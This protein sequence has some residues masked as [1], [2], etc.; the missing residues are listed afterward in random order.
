MSNLTRVSPVSQLLLFNKKCRRKTGAIL[1]SRV[2]TGALK[3]RPKISTRE[4]RDNKDSCSPRDNKRTGVTEEFTPINGVM[5]K[6]LEEKV[7]R[8]L[9]TN[10]FMREQ[11]RLNGK[12]MELNQ[13]S[14]TGKKH[15]LLL[16][17]K[18]GAIPELREPTGALKRRP[19]I[20]T[21]GQRDNRDSCS[22]R[23]N[24]KTGAIEEFTPMS[25]AIMKLP[26]ERARR[27]LMTNLFTKEQPRPNGNSMVLNQQ[28]MTGKKL[29]LLLSK[30]GE[31]GATPE[32]RELPGVPVRKPLT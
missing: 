5:M 24:K 29:T 32:S 16:R 2:P 21:R 27:L 22:P 9:M 4:P 6:S 14:M 26:E 17:R 23:D 19:R 13:Q 15:I 1:V 11:P 3:R 18:T 10:L 31:T 30:E 20:S 12:L 8:P 25:G 28:S 7:R